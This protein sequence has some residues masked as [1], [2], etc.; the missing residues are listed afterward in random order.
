MAQNLVGT[1]ILANRQTA[2]Y[3]SAQQY[4]KSF[5]PVGLFSLEAGS[6]GGRRFATVELRVARGRRSIPLR[7]VPGVL[8]KES[9]EKDTK[10]ATLEKRVADFQFLYE[11]GT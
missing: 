2:T 3:F 8:K 5:G 11:A 6:V 7:L 9:G 1:G 4:G 10:I